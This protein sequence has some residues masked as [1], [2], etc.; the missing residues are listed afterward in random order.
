MSNSFFA[1][2]FKGKKN[3]DSPAY[4]REMAQKIAGH[5]I[6]YV[7]EK[8]NGVEEVIGREGSIDVRHDEFIVFASSEVILRCDVDKLQAWELLSKDGVVVTAPDKE[9]GGVERTIIVFYVYYR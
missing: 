8:I 2:L 6:R 1:R 9:H 4:R 3:P 7:T 5:R